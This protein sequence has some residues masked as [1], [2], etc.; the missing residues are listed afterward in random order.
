M[1]VGG[2]IR[3]SDR[4]PRPRR[5]PPGPS[6]SDR[7]GER[8]EVAAPPRRPGPRPTRAPR[9]PGPEPT[10]RDRPAAPVSGAIPERPRPSTGGRRVG[11]GGGARRVWRRT[12]R[13]SRELR[14]PS[15]TDDPMRSSAP[16]RGSGNTLRA[17]TATSPRGTPRGTGTT[18][19]RP[20]NV[21]DDRRPIGSNRLPVRARSTAPA[22]P[23][24]PGAALRRRGDPLRSRAITSVTGWTK[25]RSDDGTPA[26]EPEPR[27]VRTEARSPFRPCRK[28]V[29]GTV[30]RTGRPSRRPSC[31]RGQRS[32]VAVRGRRVSPCLRYPREGV[33]GTSD[34]R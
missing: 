16:P 13:A 26:R 10:G 19:S 6:T 32:G 1:S 11:V 7:R 3:R 30:G 15:R 31:R 20:P 2:A 8:A 21:P 12:A 17:G 23:D 28:G 4:H 5:T 18:R 27:G 24:G 34:S 25:P 22:P 33:L 14:R 9:T 29:R